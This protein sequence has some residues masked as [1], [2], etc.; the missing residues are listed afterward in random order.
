VYRRRSM[1]MTTIRPIW[2]LQ[3]TRLLDSDTC[4]VDFIEGG[5]SHRVRPKGVRVFVCGARKQTLFPGKAIHSIGGMNPTQSS[6]A[7]RSSK[8]LVPVWERNVLVSS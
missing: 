6:S 4:T 1:M 5:P 8:F 3:D 2:S 7:K